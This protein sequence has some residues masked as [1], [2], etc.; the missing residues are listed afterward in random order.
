MI[1]TY[2]GN[3]D[4]TW[5]SRIIT[6]IGSEGCG[7][8]IRFDGWFLKDF[9]HEERFKDS[10]SGVV[11][12]PMK[13][14]DNGYMENATLLGGIGG[15]HIKEKYDGNNTI[16]EAVHGWTMLLESDSKFRSR[17]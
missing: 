10:P 11:S 16:I 6:D 13:I 15:N 2:Q 4:K 1:K 7:L 12:V 17:M 8:P 3:P 5:W 9:L 14:N